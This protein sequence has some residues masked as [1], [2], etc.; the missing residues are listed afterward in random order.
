MADFT[1]ALEWSDNEDFSDSEAD[2]WSVL[3]AAPFWQQVAGAQ[4]VWARRN[5]QTTEHD[6]FITVTFDH[7]GVAGDGP[8]EQDYGDLRT[9]Q[10][11]I[12]AK[13]LRFINTEE[14]PT[15]LPRTVEGS[16]FWPDYIGTG[17]PVA[18]ESYSPSPAPDAGADIATVTFKLVEPEA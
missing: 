14:F 7:F 13:Y 4:V 15:S 3:G 11:A 9:L 5:V 2:V 16:P 17:L 12:F 8:Y 10:R 1:L 6:D 18:R